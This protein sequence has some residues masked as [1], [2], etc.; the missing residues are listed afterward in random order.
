MISES[1]LDNSFPTD[2][3]LMSGYRRPFRLDP[4]GNG[5][6]ILLY[7]REDI[8]SKLS[9]E[10]KEPIE[11]F[12]VEINLRKQNKVAYKLF[13]KSEKNFC[14]ESYRSIK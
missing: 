7:V 9:L 6:G 13:F 11:S 1:K 10:E 8:P 12:F 2:Q 5:G 3:F 4:N 14:V